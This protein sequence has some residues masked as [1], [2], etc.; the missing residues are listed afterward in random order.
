M[1]PK[2]FLAAFSPWMAVDEDDIFTR[3]D[4]YRYEK[5]SRQDFEEVYRA[6][7]H[8]KQDK[9]LLDKHKCVQSIINHFGLNEEEHE[10]LMRGEPFELA[11]IDE[12]YPGRVIVEVKRH[13]DLEDDL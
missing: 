5:E 8:Y 1:N 9:T 11:S 4:A 2:E 3:E 10:S 12:E 13:Y 6:F 7:S